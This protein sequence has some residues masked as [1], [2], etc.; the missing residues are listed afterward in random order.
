MP[1]SAIPPDLAVWLGLPANTRFVWKASFDLP[2]GAQAQGASFSGLLARARPW[3]LA[4]VALGTA[5]PP[6]DRIIDPL[7]PEPPALAFAD[8]AVFEST[9]VLGPVELECSVVRPRQLKISG[10]HNVLG[11]VGEVSWT[12]EDKL[13]L[14]D[15]TAGGPTAAHILDR[16]GR[17]LVVFL[18]SEAA[19]IHERIDG[20]AAWLADDNA[21]IGGS[22][23]LLNFLAVA[24]GRTAGHASELEA[25]LAACGSETTAWAV[26]AE[27]LHMHLATTLSERLPHDRK[28]ARAWLSRLDRVREACAGAREL[29]QAL[30]NRDWAP[31][32]DVLAR[33]LEVGKAAI[34]AA[35]DAWLHARSFP[36]LVAET[37]T[38]SGRLSAAATDK[39]A[40][41]RAWFEHDLHIE[42]SAALRSLVSV[43]ASE[44]QQTYRARIRELAARAVA[45][46]E[47]LP[48]SRAG[49]PRGKVLVRVPLPHFGEGTAIE[50]RQNG[51][52][53]RASLS[54]AGVRMGNEFDRPADQ[55]V[56][57]LWSDPVTGD[58]L[59][60]VE[61]HQPTPTDRVEQALGVLQDALAG[62]TRDLDGAVDVALAL[63]NDLRAGPLRTSL[64][65]TASGEDPT[66]TDL[67]NTAMALRA[68]IVLDAVAGALYGHD[69]YPVV[70]RTLVDLDAD[71]FGAGNAVLALDDE[72]YRALVDD[73]PLLESAWWGV[74]AKLDRDLPEGDLDDVLAELGRS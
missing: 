54:L 68:R 43:H 56:I 67:E 50:L 27:A 61:W 29:E 7:P 72:T 21:W 57:L 14:L 26:R 62:E 53:F 16:N 23:D 48:G 52:S 13:L 22:E 65:T 46:R 18:A 36:Q 55:H 28:E 39:A 44:W 34:L 20:L 41:L 49:E 45:T 37:G 1:T 12:P 8:H 24:R 58:V 51:S 17:E 35:P 6:P 25:W 32:R 10:A 74:R 73:H 69:R 59:T 3:L 11:F 42:D 33:R 4:V 2:V 66:N 19:E 15:G 9:G 60:E 30:P 31:L 38:R 64:D 63:A 5:V 40:V 47:A 71:L 70:L